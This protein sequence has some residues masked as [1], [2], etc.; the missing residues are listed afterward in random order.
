MTTTGTTTVA[1]VRAMTCAKAAACHL[2]TGVILNL[3]LSN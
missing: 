3:L 2:S 1:P